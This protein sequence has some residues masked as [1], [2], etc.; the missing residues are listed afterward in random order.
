VGM[1][2]Y[3]GRGIWR[4]LPEGVSWIDSGPYEG[5]GHYPVV[6]DVV[7]SARRVAPSGLVDQ[8]SGVLAPSW[9]ELDRARVA[10]AHS[11]S[12]VEVRGR[13]E[14]GSSEEAAL[15][16]AAQVLA[17]LGEGYGVLLRQPHRYDA[18]SEFFATRLLR[19]AGWTGLN[20]AID[21]RLSDLVHRELWQGL[22][23]MSVTPLGSTLRGSWDPLGRVVQ[24]LALCPQGLSVR[25]LERMGLSV[26]DHPWMS[27]IGCLSRSWIPMS[28]RHA[29]LGSM[30][31]EMRARLHAEIFDAT[32]PSGWGYLRRG[33]HGAS[34]RSM[35][36]VLSQHAAFVAAME[37]IGL[38]V[39]RSYSESLVRAI[40]DASRRP[41]GRF[42]SFLNAARLQPSTKSGKRRACT[43]YRRA[44]PLSPS[45]ADEVN[46][47]YEL[48]NSY[49]TQRSKES[50][51]IARRWYARGYR[52]AKSITNPEE[53]A[54]AQIRLANG[55]ALVEYHEGRNED[56]L[57]LEQ[58][59]RAVCDAAAPEY[60]DVERWAR[61]LL[62]TNTAKLIAKRFGDPA[63]AQDVLRENL[64]SETASVQT[65]AMLDLG[66]LSFDQGDYA[67]VDRYLRPLF[68]APDPPLM[69][70]AQ[71]LLGRFL[72]ALSAALMGASDVASSQVGR[73]RYL[74]R[75][76]EAD[77]S[78]PLIRLLERQVRSRPEE[79]SVKHDPTVRGSG[80]H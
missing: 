69:P 36:R 68:H 72:L 80:V 38:D 29:V 77:Q 13:D 44:L 75:T 17:S 76:V 1:T 22:R 10:S 3:V 21:A 51:R 35:R 20:I 24:V 27:E 45:A 73:L 41:L 9:E 11:L 50:L 26:S 2:V 8:L 60:P 67:A 12:Q 6:L 37:L 16:V 70:E 46:V 25:T 57:L 32:D 53:I 59:A 42:Y 61:P 31:Q 40:G 23:K 33:M 19:E 39:L 62:N 15:I 56:A 78:L 48:A 7:G 64:S 30:T 79:G 43:F 4:R 71:E 65:M 28:H 54:Y 18:G 63:R 58:R 52:V 66:K 5:P 74:V 47:I 34:S 55:L 49:A 14:T